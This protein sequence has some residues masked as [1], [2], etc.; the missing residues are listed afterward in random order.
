MFLEL[1]QLLGVCSVPA[2]VC[3]A[4]MV[5]ILLRRTYLSGL[6]DTDGSK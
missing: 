6:P 4:C 1:Y 3:V 2:D 5:F